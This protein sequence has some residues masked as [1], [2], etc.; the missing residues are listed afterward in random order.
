MSFR[1]PRS[2]AD[3]A[4]LARRDG[5]WQPRLR[6]FLDFFYSEPSA[7]H[8]AIAADPPE[9]GDAVAD[10]YLAATAE[11][12][13]LSYRLS[14]PDWVHGTRRFLSK[15]HF[16]GP[17]GMKA[18]LLVESPTAFRRRMLFVGFDPLARPRRRGHKPAP[19]PWGRARRPP[20]PNQPFRER[21]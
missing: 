1:R 14:V 8:K 4:K 17:E 11:H 18:M 13:A 21:G 10:A 12:L 3:V 16:A 5:E 6:E 15:A 7:R 9:T 2:L 20:L 19:P